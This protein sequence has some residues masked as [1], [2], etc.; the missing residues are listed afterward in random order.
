[1]PR[2]PT[3]KARSNGETSSK[4]EKVEKK[5]KPSKS[6]KTSVPPPKKKM[7][8]SSP[9]SSASSDSDTDST[10][11]GSSVSSSS[12]SSSSSDSESET[13]KKKK[14]RERRYS[15]RKKSTKKSS[16]STPKRSYSRKASGVPSATSTPTL[17]SSSAPISVPM[18]MP[19]PLPVPAPLPTP[20]PAPVPEPGVPS[21]AIWSPVPIQKHQSRCVNHRRTPEARNRIIST[22][23]S[24][25]CKHKKEL[26][27]RAKDK[28]KDRDQLSS[29]VKAKGQSP[30]ARTGGKQTE[31][32]KENYQRQVIKVKDKE[33]PRIKDKDRRS[34]TRQSGVSSSKAPTKNERERA[35]SRA[36]HREKRLLS[37]SRERERDR[38]SVRRSIERHSNRDR[39]S[40]SRR[41]RPRRS[42]SQTSRTP[43][44]WRLSSHRLKT[45]RLHIKGLTRQVTKTHI[46]EIFGSFGPLT[47]VDFPVNH[48]HQG[49]NY[50][51]TGRG[52][53]FVEFANPKDC[54]TALRS[55]DGGKIDG[56]RIIV[57]PF[58][59]NMLR[60]PMRRRNPSPLIVR[61]H[62]RNY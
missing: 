43:S 35:G 56:H 51:R 7:K 37:H 13:E 26:V 24:P 44:P 42:R 58:Q 28:D 5:D 40:S 10:N 47:N 15:L 57:S 31:K 19:I 3:G 2:T 6:S 1:M 30:P 46:V 21:F 36:P 17:A 23:K 11:S 39:R 34:P 41:S 16:K 20:V 45:V 18:P 25:S 48:Y 4:K 22:A 38:R 9:P 32:D 14:K 60:L 59:A 50:S 27:G 54:E 29:G 61:N 62:D 53:A 49:N 52:F 33:C 12:S 55:M 8:C